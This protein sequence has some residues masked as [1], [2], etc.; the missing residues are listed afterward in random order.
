M[1]FMDLNCRMSACFSE[2]TEF[3]ELKGTKKSEEKVILK[4]KS[5]RQK[6]GNDDPLFL[7]EKVTDEKVN[8]WNRKQAIIK[9]CY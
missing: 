1:D 9:N 2:F 6:S 4:V 7:H 8:P 5:P 3:L